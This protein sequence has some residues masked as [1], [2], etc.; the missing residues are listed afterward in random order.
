MAAVFINPTHCEIIIIFLLL[1]GPRCAGIR[2]QWAQEM[3]RTAFAHGVEIHARRTKWAQSSKQIHT[4][5]RPMSYNKEARP[6]RTACERQWAKQ[7]GFS[8]KQER[9]VLMKKTC[10]RGRDTMLEFA[11]VISIDMRVRS[12]AWGM[13]M[14]DS[15]THSTQSSWYSVKWN[16]DKWRSSGR[17]RERGENH[18]RTETQSI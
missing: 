6:I 7:Y 13:E 12:F 18:E 8:G 10:E 4:E 15:N 3:K 14:V 17:E 2:K 5:R 9:R 16:K 11:A 1:L